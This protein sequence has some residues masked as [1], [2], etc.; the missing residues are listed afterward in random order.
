M[1]STTLIFIYILMCF[2]GLQ[3]VICIVLVQRHSRDGNRQLL[4][5]SRNFVIACL[6]MGFYY[7]L[8]FYR[9]QVLGHYAAPAWLRAIDAAQFYVIGWTWVQLLDAIVQSPNPRL[10]FWR[11]VVTPVF[12]I[13]TLLSIAAYVFLLNAY[14]APRFPL[15]E[16]IVLIEEA[17]LGVSVIVFTTAFYYHAATDI[18]EA[19]TRRYL[20]AVSIL[21]NFN[22]IW[23]NIVVVEIFIRHLAVGSLRL[24]L[25]G[26]TSFALLAIN[27]YTL[28]F[29]YRRDFT[30][31]YQVPAENGSASRQIRTEEEAADLVA[32][33][34]R[35]TE[36]ERQVMLLAVR[37]LTN[38]DIADQL[39]ISKYT[40]KRHMHNIFEKLD[41]STRMEL[42]HLINAQKTSSHR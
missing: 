6:V 22:N 41:V 13:L 30:P 10:R 3:G 29:I 39:C 21:V 5:A 24:Q 17:A 37:G 28:L 26:V 12:A 42:A 2:A 9:E 35:L 36:R 8:T 7:F 25:Y 18:L 4:R 32:A 19:S 23:N 14:Y 33:R 16:N 11:N 40:V 1:L 20:I 34:H 31:L 27:L 38:P 15:A